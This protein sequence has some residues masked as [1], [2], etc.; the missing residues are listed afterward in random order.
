MSMRQLLK[1]AGNG[2]MILSIA[3]VVQTVF[4]HAHEVPP[5][6][7]SSNAVLSIGVTTVFFV[8]AAFCMSWGWV[9]LLRGGNTF[10]TLVEGYRILGRAQIGKYLPGNV[11]HYV[12]RVGLS[13]ERGI[14]T[15]ATVLSTGIEAVLLVC[16]AALVGSL[17]FW[18]GGPG[19]PWLSELSS[20]FSLR[21]FPT[22]I[23][24]IV[25][26][27]ILSLLIS[28]RARSWSLTRLGYLKPARLLL[29]M[30]IYAAV[31]LL[32]GIVIAQLVRGLWAAE[33]TVSW[34]EYSAGFSIAWVLG[35]IVPGASAGLGIREAVFV[36]L[37]GG[38]IG[39]GLAVGLAILLR[40]IT[41]TSDM[42]TF[43][44]A[45]WLARESPV[46]SS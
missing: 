8:V 22:L 39:Q 34:W 15:E 43:G 23:G 35:F 41:S 12:G 16:S 40:I 11:F 21:S 24:L 18:T 26:A 14:S 36:A 27:S 20:R 1:Y 10:I 30:S 46:R 42:I 37:F 28:K 2:L 6:R 25:V 45:S 3:F 32:N 5:V 9:L 4:R 29:V 19:L 17:V 44:I 7:S 31:L 33:S 13:A 38:A